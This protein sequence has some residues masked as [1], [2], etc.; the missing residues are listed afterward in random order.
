MASA[1]FNASLSFTPPASNTVSQSFSLK[2]S[3][4]A[5]SL[6]TIDVDSGSTT[7]I[8]VPFGGSTAAR[9]VVV[10]NNLD[11]DVGV[12]I[13]GNSANLYDLA[14]GGML[15]HWAP[16]DAQADN[17]A[18]ITLTPATATVAAGTIEYVV[19]GE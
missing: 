7:A 17:L 1:S 12:R 11:V 3:Y 9:G 16:Q 19:L 15:M 13:N 14:P 8:E 18:A 6:G 4:S 10:R 2:L 5:V